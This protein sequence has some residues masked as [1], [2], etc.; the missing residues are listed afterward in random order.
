MT[1]KLFQADLRKWML[2]VLAAERTDPAVAG[3]V[4]EG[5]VQTSLRG[6][7][8]HGVR[9]FPHYVRTLRAGGVNGRPAYSF[10]RTAPSCGILDADHT[11][12][13]AAGGE[14]MRRAIEMAR[15]AGVGSVAVAHS[16]HFGAAAYFGLMAAEQNMIGLAFT[17]ADALLL[18]SGG[19]QPYLGPNPVCFAAPCDGESP[20]C[21]DMS[22]SPISWN[23]IRQ[24]REREE[25]LPENVA[26]DPRG[27]ETTDP[28]Q[29]RSLLPIGDYKG[30][31]L[32]MMV[33][34]LCSLLTGMNYGK[35]LSPMFEVP[36]DLQR[37]LG[38]FFMA[39][40]ISRFTPV[41]VF[42]A[43]LKSMMDELRGEPRLRPSAPV[44]VPGDPE[45]NSVRVREVEGIPFSDAEWSDFARLAQES[46][47][48][49]PSPVP[50]EAAA[51]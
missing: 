19:T 12:G 4:V 22:C 26:A 28:L 34:I 48:P 36:P 15:D 32:A 30:Y 33:E 16:S 2:D 31:G 18:T 11:F 13:H 38:H 17:H 9:L 41:P 39:I 43:R 50:C 46:R 44:M 10:Q 25:P 1:S 24:Y 8:S 14:A 51:S 27:H 5:L 37:N 7:D 49:L 23:K 42:K 47:L 45:K 3:H 6:V 20:F 21:L 35:H 40:D 29:A